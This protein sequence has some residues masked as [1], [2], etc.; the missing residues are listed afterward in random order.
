[1]QQFLLS[2]GRQPVLV[3][4]DPANEFV[5]YTSDVSVTEIL[6]VTSIMT[7]HRLG[8]NGALLY[9][10][11]E[12]E[13][14][15]M[16]WLLDRLASFPEDSYFIFDL[17]GQVEITTCNPSLLHIIRTLQKHSFQLAVV[18]LADAAYCADPF[19]YISMLIVTLKSMMQLECPQINVLSKLDLV[20][21][22]GQ[23][24]FRLEYYL[25]VQ[26]LRYLLAAL[27]EDA[28]GIRY[29][30]LSA[31]LC[32]LVEEA[33]LLTFVPLAVEDKDCMAF[34]LGEVDK[35]NGYVFGALTAGNETILEAAVSQAHRERVI[36]LV[37]DRYS[38]PLGDVD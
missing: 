38:A 6:T 7:R 15:R 13:T 16:D 5:P 12:L 36:D 30:K 24:P 27:E 32:E 23:L 35:A 31:A 8:P 29:R 33:G 21:S 25:N 22:Y 34:L 14:H 9:C 26:D 19:K 10:L 11:K 28:V 4:L 2:L 17:P 20:K 37:E 18:H 3:N 1:M